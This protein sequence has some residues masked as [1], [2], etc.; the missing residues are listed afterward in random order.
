MKKI[1]IICGLLGLAAAMNAAPATYQFAGTTSSALTVNN[2]TNT[3][4]I[5]AG[6]PYTGTLTYD[7]AQ[8]VTPVSYSGGTHTVYNFTQ[9]TMTVN[10]TT[11]SFGPG[12][13]DVFD[14]LVSQVS[15]PSGDSLYVNISGS[16][17]P[18]GLLNGSQ[19]NYIYLALLD[20]TGTAIN[21]GRLP[22][23]LSLANF[24]TSSFVGF[25][26][27]TGGV[28]YGAGNTT[29]IQFLS[30]LSNSTGGTTP[31]TI[32]T[33]ALPSG[34]V[35][36]AYSAAINTATPNGNAK[37]V[38]V[39]GLPSGL[40]F[41]GAAIIGTPL[42]VGTSQ[43]TVSVVDTVTNLSTS[44]SLPLTINA[45]PISFAPAL[46]DGVVNTSYVASFQ[47][48]TGG[49]GVFTYGVSGLPAGLTLTGTTL[50]GLPTVPGTYPLIL[51]AT[52]SAGA[53]ASA[54]VNLRISNPTQTTCAGTNA[55]IS[56]YVARNPG[57]IVVNGGLNLLDHLWTTLLNS[58]NT[59][60][61]GG[62]VNWFQT[63]LIV[64]YTGTSDPAG[65]ILTSLTVK[66]KVTISTTYLANGKVGVAYLAPVSVAWGAAPYSVTVS[67][68][69][70]GL[71]FNGQD[72]TGT[73]QV[74]GTFAVTIT[75]IDGVGATA[76]MAV[77]LTIDPAPA[78][79]YTAPDEG[80]GKIT[81]IGADY[82]MIGAKKLIWNGSTSIK[83]NTAN[84]P[85]NSITS[86]V[87]V[88]MKAQWKGLRDKA[89]NTV[90]TAK[91]EIN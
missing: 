88:G 64:D 28:P 74:A 11:V 81:A 21:G 58:G 47:A 55:V 2:G 26:Y 43:V 90:L 16:V 20:A 65:C 57:F 62:L 27:G 15:Y 24:Q 8:A 33:S 1:A 51:T 91:L 53:T 48:A 59:T 63:G 69:P 78:G 85:L 76:T 17:A 14:N 13:I 73:P 36:V 31:P 89:T 61:Q 3:G 30:S 35:G 45:A 42:A 44:R 83:V 75:A 19:F 5:P 82:V 22:A 9:M 79:N 29:T 77:A 52:D 86:F 25:N 12:Q 71:T 38:S 56:A 70:G 10:G 60:F 67:G 40:S 87:K 41:D 4:N 32:L 49:N 50:S 66:P 18:N 54:I 84:G 46:P 39:A 7:D 72:V 80:L 6:T 23:N 68:L 34:V 37:T